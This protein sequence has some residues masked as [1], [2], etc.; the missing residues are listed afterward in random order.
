MQTNKYRDAIKEEIVCI[1][2]HSFWT[3]SISR[4]VSTM[5]R[6]MDT[7]TAVTIRASF[8]FRSSLYCIFTHLQFRS[9]CCWY[10]LAC[11]KFF[12]VNLS[13]IPKSI[14]FILSVL[15]EKCMSFLGLTQNHNQKSIHES[16]SPSMNRITN[17]KNNSIV[18]QRTKK[19]SW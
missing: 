19:I 16:S 9:Y 8:L 2:F 11:T 6:W 17:G 12:S 18:S 5:L 15:K 14:Y 7:T 13:F 1:G 3:L 4:N 10:L